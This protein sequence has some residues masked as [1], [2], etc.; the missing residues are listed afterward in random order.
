MI[1]SVNYLNEIICTQYLQQ[2]IFELN[3]LS[4]PIQGRFLLKVMDDKKWL[5]K[6]FT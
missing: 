6:F 3:N 4:R 5:L 1:G 2:H